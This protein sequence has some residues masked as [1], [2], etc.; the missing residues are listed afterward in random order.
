M[1]PWWLRLCLSM[2]SFP[3]PSQ[4]L[5]FGA[6][7]VC[8]Q[9][10]IISQRMTNKKSIYFSKFNNCLT[11]FKHNFWFLSPMLTVVIAHFSYHIFLWKVQKLTLILNVI[12]IKQD[13]NIW[14]FMYYTSDCNMIYTTIQK[15]GV[16]KTV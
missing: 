5:C 4:M 10:R 1:E 12:L 15:F 11:A 13:C 8:K 3:G 9:H 14:I 6:L 2:M 7:E 16:C